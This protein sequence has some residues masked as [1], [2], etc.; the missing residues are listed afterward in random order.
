MKYK[1][2]TEVTT[3]PITLSQAKNH[4]RLDSNSFSDNLTTY[5]SITPQN[6][7]VGVITGESFDVLAK[8]VIVNLNSGTNGSSG[9]VDVKIQESEDNSTFTDWYSFSQVTESNDN[10][11]FEKAY[12]GTK[13]YLRCVATVSTS[14][15]NFSCDILV[16]NGLSEE[17][18]MI[19]QFISAS[20]EFGEDYT[21][22]SF[23]SQTIEMILNDFPRCSDVVNWY[24]NP[25]QSITSVKYTNSD[26]VETTMVEG[27]DY[28]VDND[29]FEGGVF[30]PYS[31]QW[32][33]FIPYPYNAVRIRGICGYSG[34]V[35][36]VLPQNYI[37]AMLLHVGYMYKFRDTDIP[38]THM[39]TLYNLYS[40]RRV[41]WL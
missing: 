24:L 25:L 35:P 3:E 31:G 17:D 14:A 1:I 33:S 29:P 38:R 28:I 27:T 4:L 12:T 15:C 19:T 41:R 7:N 6:N 9:T 34:T 39:R 5:Q 30:L 32:P 13:Q 11:I 37:N 2:I 18:T 20:R 10:Q 8:N 22:H 23:A 40:M 16:N 26:G 36:Y 21:G